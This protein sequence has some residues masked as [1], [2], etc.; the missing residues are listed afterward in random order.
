MQQDPAVLTLLAAVA[1][2]M[3][4]TTALVYDRE[5]ASGNEKMAWTK[6]FP[7]KVQLFIRLASSSV[8]KVVP[9]APAE[10]FLAMLEAKKD[11][12][13][14]MVVHAIKTQRNGTQLIDQPFSN[15]LYAGTLYNSEG[16]DIPKGLSTFFSVPAPIIGG[17]S[18]M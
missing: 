6:R 5:T 15:A 8:N 9:K 2:N 13:H 7:N 1:D 11:Q 12:A 16:N 4:K 14:T 18:A 3:A 17:K 10:E